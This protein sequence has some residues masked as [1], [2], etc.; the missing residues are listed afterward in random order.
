MNRFKR[1]I[2]LAF[3]L[4]VPAVVFAATDNALTAMIPQAEAGSMV[5]NYILLLIGSGLVVGFLVAF[6]KIA[7]GFAF[8]QIVKSWNQL[9][10]GKTALRFGT[11]VGCYDPAVIKIGLFAVWTETTEDDGKVVTDRVPYGLLVDGRVTIVSLSGRGGK[12]K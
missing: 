4:M 6:Q 11:A 9:V 5:G 7:Q 3:A 2:M 8:G 1:W 10:V 12:L